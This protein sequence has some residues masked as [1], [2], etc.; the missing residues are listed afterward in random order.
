MI[1]YVFTNLKAYVAGNILLLEG[2]WSV[3]IGLV[4]YGEPVTMAIAIGALLVVA[5]AVAINKIDDRVE[6][7]PFLSVGELE[8]TH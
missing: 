2:V 8:K 7:A 6:E 5:S 1:N 3:I 4:I